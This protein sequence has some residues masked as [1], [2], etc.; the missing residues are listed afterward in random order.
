MRK[1]GDAAHW[2]F[3]VEL[4]GRDEHGTWLAARPPTAYT[5]PRGAGEGT[6]DFLILLPPGQGWNAAFNL[7]AGRPRPRGR[8]GRRARPPATPPP[9]P[10]AGAGPPSPGSSF[11]PPGRRGPS[12][13]PRQDRR[14]AGRTAFSAA[15][16]GGS[17]GPQ[18]PLQPRR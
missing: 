3:V 11:H 14:V 1:W 13:P 9:P 8:R 5:G 10:S 18:P 2:R 4:L 7:H 16:A 17:G 6:H 12:R 15:H